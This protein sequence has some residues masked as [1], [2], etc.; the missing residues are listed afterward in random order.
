MDADKARDGPFPLYDPRCQT[1][2]DGH[3]KGCPRDQATI[4]ERVSGWAVRTL[5]H[6]CPRC[7]RKVVNEIKEGS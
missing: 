5:N 1:D 7:H 2:L 3:A 4:Q 6:V